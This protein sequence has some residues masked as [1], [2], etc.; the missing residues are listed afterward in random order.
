MIRPRTLIASL[1]LV[2][3]ILACA[4]PFVPPPTLGPEQLATGVAQTLQAMATALPPPAPTE[5]PVP[6]PTVVNLLPHPLYFLNKDA[7]GLLQIFRLDADGHTLQQITFEPAS[8]DSYD[9][10]HKDGSVAY[11][12]NNQLYLV[13]SE[14]AGRRLLVDG[15]PLDDNNRWTHSVGAPVFSPD[16]QTLAFSHGGLNFHALSSGVTTRVLENQVDLSAGF[17]IVRELYAPAAYSPDGSRLLIN[18]GHYEGGS[19]GLYLPS[20]SELIRFKRADG[21][22]ACCY[23]NWVPN[24]SGVYL[25]SPSMGHDETG[26]FYADAASGSV[27]SL[28][29]GAPPDGTYNF[30]FAA[31]VGAD[32]KLYFFFNNLST[33]PVSNHTPL[34]LV[35]SNS[36]GVTDRTRLLPDAFQNVNEVLWA[37]DASLAVVVAASADDQS[38]SGQARIIYPDG[39]PAVTLVPTAQDLRWGP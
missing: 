18:I 15:G 4:T 30:A 17:P 24:G 31:Q 8:V 9:V 28:L 35:R 29:P 11:S 19:Y 33:V 25:T 20:S 7:G 37:P 2:S 16:G 6:T 14:G 23:V 3:A 5:T 21:R 34:Y 12:T 26:L 27:T 36:D 10:S 13:D 1:A 32:G 39:R 38:A 22:Q